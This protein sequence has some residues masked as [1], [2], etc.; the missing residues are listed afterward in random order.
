MT[1]LF[2]CDWGTSSFRLYL[3]RSS[4]RTVLDQ[5]QSP[6]GIKETDRLWRASDEPDR[7]LFFR[8]IL[9]DQIRKFSQQCVENTDGFHVLLSG[10]ASS[11]IGM[12]ELPYGTLPLDLDAPSIP[13]EFLPADNSCPWPVTL[14]SGIASNE[15]V[16]R[17]EEV[18]LLG[19]SRRLPEQ[20]LIIL[21]PGTHSK[22]LYIKGRR[23]EAF[24]TWMT[25]E[26]FDVIQSSTILASSLGPFEEDDPP[27]AFLEGVRDAGKQEWLH[28]LFTIRARHVLNANAEERVSRSYL[29]GLL[30]GCELAG[31]PEPESTD[32]F[33]TG[34][35]ALEPLYRSALK[36]L[37]YRIVDLQVPEPLTVAGQLHWLELN[38]DLLQ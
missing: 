14:L 31:L 16:M 23:M 8:R 32:L 34:A 7:T 30:I 10:M 12:N 33:V 29:S 24:K 1:H 5:Y 36:E 15:D 9:A 37:D 6:V 22:H 11:S 25:G 13:S 4:D 17:G 35:P 19:L 28:T 18:Q 21:L 2:C 3:V 20:D 26:L 38:S 27:Q